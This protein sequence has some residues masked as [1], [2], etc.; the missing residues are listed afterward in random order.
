MRMRADDYEKSAKEEKTRLKSTV[1]SKAAAVEVEYGEDQ[2]RFNLVTFFMRR[3]RQVKRP[4]LCPSALFGTI[5]YF[6]I[7]SRRRVSC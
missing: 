7:I 3:S 1:V 6:G 4:L 2:V 5:S